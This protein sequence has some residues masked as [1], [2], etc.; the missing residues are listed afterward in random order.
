MNLLVTG[1]GGQ[2]GKSIKRVSKNFFNY[3]FFFKIRENLDISNLNDVKE[4]IEDFNID[5]V[6]NCAAYTN[7]NDAEINRK[8]NFN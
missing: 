2:L 7:V 6:I 8:R 4:C 5:V 3:N 1:S